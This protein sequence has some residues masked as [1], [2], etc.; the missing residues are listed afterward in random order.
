MKIIDILTYPVHLGGNHV[1]VKVLTDEHL[2]GIG[3][4]YRVGPDEAVEQT[5]HY[6]GR[7]GS[8]T[9]LRLIW[10]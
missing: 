3:E 1:F 7:P 5:I 8:V 6:F 10:S 9:R 4:A 2:Y